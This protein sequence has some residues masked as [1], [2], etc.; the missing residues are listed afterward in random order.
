MNNML[1]EKIIE[2]IKNRGIVPR[3]R[4]HFLL[5]RSVLWSLV[6][7]A[8]IFGGIAVAVII[9]IFIDHDANAR[10]YLDE[11]IFVDLLETIPYLWF[12]ALFLLIGITQYVI[13][14][15]KSGY[16][17]TTARIV[18]VVVVSSVVLGIVLSALEVGERV[19]DFLVERAPYYDKITN[20]SKDSWSHPEKGLLG[21]MI[22]EV[23]SSDEFK[24][25]DFHDKDWFIDRSQIE[26][27]DVAIIQLGSTIK[28]IG[29]QEDTTTFRAVQVLPWK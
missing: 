4:W 8:T 1:P 20:T 18:G 24:L 12:G 22:T 15:T 11:S 25:T 19:Q 17:Y 23:V 10:A 7:I 14:H 9:F 3:P 21:G 2:E 27:A 29:T 5:K 26:D 16:R 28:M 6:A 13:R